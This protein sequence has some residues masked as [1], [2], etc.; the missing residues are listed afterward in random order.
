MSGAMAADDESRD[1]NTETAQHS[2]GG[3]GLAD[4]SPPWCLR[5]LALGWKH[6]VDSLGNQDENGGHR[7]EIEKP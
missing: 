1:R 6:G 4:L 3:D 2:S 7:L 5:D